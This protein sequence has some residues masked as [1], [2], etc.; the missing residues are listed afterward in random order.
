MK[1]L[2]KSANSIELSREKVMTNMDKYADT[3]GG[4]IPILVDEVIRS[5]RLKKGDTLL[6]QHLGSGWIYGASILK[7]T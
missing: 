3:S 2:V 1:E 7:W 4:T 5:G 6:L